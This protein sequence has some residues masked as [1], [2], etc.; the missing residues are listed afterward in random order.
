MFESDDPIFPAHYRMDLPA[1]GPDLP[2]VFWINQ[3]SR[4][5]VLA[6]ADSYKICTDKTESTCWDQITV[7]K[8]LD[9]F[10]NDLE[11]QRALYLLTIAFQGTAAWQLTNYIGLDALKATKETYKLAGIR[12]DPEQ[13]KVEV[14]GI[15]D[16]ELASMQTRLYDYSRG[17]YANS[18]RWAEHDRGNTFAAPRQ[19]Q[20]CTHRS[21]DLKT[22]QV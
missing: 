16:A 21:T 14:D 20:K 7:S 4:A 1:A 12:L 17:T 9:L 22:F 15:F 11:R 3:F 6:C 13:W 10:E 5:G 2:S 19:G 8:A 18:A